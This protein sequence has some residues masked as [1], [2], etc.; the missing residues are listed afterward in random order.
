MVS[1]RDGGSGFTFVFPLFDSLFSLIVVLKVSL[2]VREGF[3]KG[4]PFHLS[5]LFSLQRL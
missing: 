5:S 2:E 1:L 4:I 3:G